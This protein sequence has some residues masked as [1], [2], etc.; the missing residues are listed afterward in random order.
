ME[1]NGFFVSQEA[2]RRLQK[3]FDG[4]KEKN[5]PNSNLLAVKLSEAMSLFEPVNGNAETEEEQKLR[6]LKGSVLELWKY[7][8]N[9]PNI[10]IAEKLRRRLLT[11]S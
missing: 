11:K 8:E 9:T 5:D 6:D 2:M 3:V 10:D 4:L 1:V 7:E